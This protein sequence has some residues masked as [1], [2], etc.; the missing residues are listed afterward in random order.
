MAPRFFDGHDAVLC[1]L[2]GVVYAGDHAVAG[3]VETLRELGGRG[4]PVAYVTNNASRAPEAVAAHLNAFGLEVTGDRVFGSAAAGVALLDEVLGGRAA[5]VLVVGSDHLRSL[6]G[7]AGHRVVG[8]AAEAPDAVIQ[9]FDPSVC[10]ADL[11][12]ASYAVRAGARWV[13]TNTDLTIPRAE[14][15]APGNGALV[16]AVARATGTRPVAAGKPEPVLFR[17]AARAVGARRPLVVGDRLDT[18]IL[19]GN[20][21]GFDTALV[22]TGVDDRESAAA[23]PAEQQPTWLLAGLPDLLGRPPQRWAPG[24]RP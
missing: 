2:D 3:A 11:A 5:R 17:M 18:D 14:G 7:A 4:V 12:E 9:G 20:R 10:W 24:E 6:V 13:A 16:E 8:S 22:L 23:A 1:D 19:G 21:S 15:I